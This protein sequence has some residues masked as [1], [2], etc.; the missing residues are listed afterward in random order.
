MT[1]K[2]AATDTALLSAPVAF[3]L[4]R[5]P[6]DMV[7]D[8][9]ARRTLQAAS[10]LGSRVADPSDV[11]T[12]HSYQRREPLQRHAPSGRSRRRAERSRSRLT[13][14]A[15]ARRGPRRGQRVLFAR[16]ARRA[17]GFQTSKLVAAGA[18][19]SSCQARRSVVMSPPH[20]LAGGAR[21]PPERIHSVLFSRQTEKNAL[22]S[23]TL[24]DGRAHD[25]VQ[26]FALTSSRAFASTCPSRRWS[27]AR[28]RT[29][30]ARGACRGAC[31]SSPCCTSR[32][33][34]TPRRGS[35]RPRS[36]T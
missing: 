8:G 1:P 2:R 22:T 12:F 3:A 21:L 27:L 20:P 10:S 13:A 32:S 31:A 11:L 6:R 35:A 36:A 4:R 28:A 23:T 25:R 5:W 14:N 15:R 30:G 17:T 33:T 34:Q 9:E 26:A 18:F 7:T 24:G 16:A 29:C 19:R